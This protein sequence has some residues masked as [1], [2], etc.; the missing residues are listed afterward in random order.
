[1]LPARIHILVLIKKPYL[2][3]K[4]SMSHPTMIWKKALPG[5]IPT[6]LPLT[7]LASETVPIRRENLGGGLSGSGIKIMMW[8]GP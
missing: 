7:A 3:E 5:I 4:I 2:T 8:S 6:A 1:M